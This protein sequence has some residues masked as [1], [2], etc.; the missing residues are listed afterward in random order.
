MK[1]IEAEFQVTGWDEGAF[2]EESRSGTVT[3]RKTF[4]GAVEGTSVARLL[5]A[6]APGG[7]GRGYVASEFFTG[8]IEGA[9]GTLLFQHGGLDDGQAPFTF[10]NIVPLS[11]TGEL[12][13]LSGTVEFRHTEAGAFVKFALS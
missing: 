11:G 13:G 9:K 3:V 8:S 5:S 2:D 6:E 10:G 1:I 4:T 12:A 7:V